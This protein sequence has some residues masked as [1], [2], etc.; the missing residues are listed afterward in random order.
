MPFISSAG[1]AM[2]EKCVCNRKFDSEGGLHRH[3]NACKAFKQHQA[4]RK[5]DR[6]EADLDEELVEM[7]R[8]LAE[9][10][11]RRRREEEAAMRQLMVSRNVNWD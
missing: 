2:P 4:R 5:R 7:D 10:E 9:N 6:M 11:R 3:Q 1:V 8:R